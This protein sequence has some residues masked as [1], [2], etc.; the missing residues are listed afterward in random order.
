M[1]LPFFVLFFLAGLP[2]AVA[3]QPKPAPTFGILDNSFLVEEAFNQDAGVFQNIFV[4]QRSRDGHWNGAFTQEWP[5]LSMRHQASFTLPFS[6]VDGTS[7]VGDLALNYRLQVWEEGKVRP[8]FAPRLTVIMPTSADRTWADGAN[9]QFNLPFSKEVRRVYLHGN[10]GSSFEPDGATPFVAASAIVAVTPFFNVMLESLF[11][12]VSDE[13]AKNVRRTVSPG[14]RAGWNRKDSQWVIGFALPVVR[15]A[16]RD[17]A[18]L[19]YLS[20]ELPF[21]K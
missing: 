13:G 10:A 14:V 9:W 6:F 1:R 4:L 7:A 20:Y 19:G 11:E 3:A 12:F 15:G 8:A 21:R 5:V 18:A 16:G 17:V 2:S